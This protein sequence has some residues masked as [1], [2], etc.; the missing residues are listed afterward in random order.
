MF[1]LIPARSTISVV[2]EESLFQVKAADARALEPYWIPLR[3]YL[4]QLPF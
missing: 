3:G 4:P 2:R 1:F